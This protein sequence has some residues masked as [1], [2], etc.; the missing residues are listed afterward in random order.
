MAISSSNIIIVSLLLLSDI[1][2][3]QISNVPNKL[4]NICPIST[5]NVSNNLYLDKKD[6][7]YS[8]WQD[9]LSFPLNDSLNIPVYPYDSLSLSFFSQKSIES[10]AMPL[11]NISNPE[12]LAYCKW[13]ST[14]VSL[15]KQNFTTGQSNCKGNDYYMRFKT[16]DPQNEYSI[17]FE[18]ALEELLK[19][20]RAKGFRCMAKYVRNQ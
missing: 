4:L 13:R 11:Q 15:F 1:S 10:P 16:A 17:Q 5:F 12:L 9:Y 18:P 6:I 7:T 2:L 14:V 19:K 8:D 20:N 3:G